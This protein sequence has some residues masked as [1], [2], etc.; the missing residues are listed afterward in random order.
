MVSDEK[1]G[2]TKYR[3]KKLKSIVKRN[4]LPRLSARPCSP[5]LPLGLALQTTGAVHNVC[6][7][8]GGPSERHPVAT[9]LLAV[10]DRVR[11]RFVPIL[12]HKGA[13][14]LTESERE[15]ENIL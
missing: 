5:F 1:R 13:F 7:V 9:Q 3:L 4:S 6:Q 15:V 8:D 12:K 11:L 2:R 14:T 10:V